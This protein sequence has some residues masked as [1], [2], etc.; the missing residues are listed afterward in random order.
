MAKYRFPAI[1]LNGVI[2][3]VVAYDVTILSMT[4]DNNDYIM[5]LNAPISEDEVIHLNESYG[6][7][8]V[9]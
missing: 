8:E 3:H 2:S 9:V 5:E 6:L 7:V 1:E 4:P